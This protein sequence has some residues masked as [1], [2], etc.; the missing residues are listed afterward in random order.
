VLDDAFA[1]RD[2]AVPGHDHVAIPADA[3]N[4]SGTNQALLRHEGD[5]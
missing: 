3:K 2:L 1:K 5:L 4:C